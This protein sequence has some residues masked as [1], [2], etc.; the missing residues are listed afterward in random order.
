MAGVRATTTGINGDAD[1]VLNTAKGN[2]VSIISVDHGS[3]LLED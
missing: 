2:A 3:S 1:V